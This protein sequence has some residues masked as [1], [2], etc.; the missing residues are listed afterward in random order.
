VFNVRPQ[1]P[2]GNGPGVEIGD[3]LVVAERYVGRLDEA[4]HE[5]QALL[6]QVKVHPPKMKPLG[7]NSTANQAALYG[8]WPPFNWSSATLRSLPGPFPRTPNPGPCDAAQFAIIDP[9]SITFEAIP[10]ELRGGVAS[11]GNP[12][13]LAGQLARTVRLDLG[14]DATPDGGNGW[15][16]IVEDMLAIAPLKAFREAGKT[17][18][19]NPVTQDHRAAGASRGRFVV[20]R[21]AIADQGILD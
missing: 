17:P 10:L 20:L 16:R 19:V 7:T 4:T 18:A 21:I 9:S 6:L 12:R 1:C 13:D 11:F 8:H 5:R 15:P 2:G 14:V 3:L